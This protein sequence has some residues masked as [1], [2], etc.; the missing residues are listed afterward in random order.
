[1]ASAHAAIP[2]NIGTTVKDQRIVTENGVTCLGYTDLAICLPTTSSSLY[3]N[4]IS[5]FLLSMGLMTT[6]VKDHYYVDHTNDAIW[7]MLA[8]EGGTLMWPAPLPPPRP[9]RRR[10]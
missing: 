6:K 7:G 1:V 9:R 10:T 2:G 3:S 8:V 5:K 4:N